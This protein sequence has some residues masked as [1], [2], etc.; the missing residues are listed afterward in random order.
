MGLIKQTFRSQLLLQLLKLKIKITDSGRRHRY[1]HDLK[2][3]AALIYRR[4]G[5]DNYLVTVFGTKGCAAIIG[6][7]HDAADLGIGILE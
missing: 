3:A 1:N 6:S 4:M 7:E 2:L 5:T